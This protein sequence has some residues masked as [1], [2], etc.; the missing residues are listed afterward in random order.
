MSAFAALD[1]GDPNQRVFPQKDELRATWL[2]GA[3]LSWI[4]NDGLV[5]GATRARIEAE[6]NQLRADRVDL[7]HE[8]SL[9]VLDATQAVAIAQRAIET[10][11]E[12]VQA[13]EAGYRV[14]K[15][16]FAAGRASVVEII[17]VETEL[18]RAR[19]SALDARID[20]RIALAKLAYTT[21][22]SSVED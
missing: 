22:D 18:T 19:I 17:D 16:L 9:Q 7:E 21:G 2:V 15:D 13:A 1:Y 6:A 14:R 4:L 8:I 12:G 5:A 3:Q 10:S 20:L 11:R